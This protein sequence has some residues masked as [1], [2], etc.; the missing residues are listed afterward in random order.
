VEGT[1]HDNRAAL[2]LPPGNTSKGP[3][4]VVEAERVHCSVIRHV[5]VIPVSLDRWDLSW[6][7]YEFE[8]VSS[9]GSVWEA[10]RTSKEVDVSD[11][12]GV[13]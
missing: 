4:S 2:L 12:G 6:G 5:G 8:T 1:S 9:K 11:E 3:A 7:A 10:V 13:R